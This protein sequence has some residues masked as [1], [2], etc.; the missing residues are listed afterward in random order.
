MD[1]SLEPRKVI[2]LIDGLCD[3]GKGGEVCVVRTSVMVGSGLC[4]VFTFVIALQL[5]TSRNILTQSIGL[6]PNIDRF[7]DH[8]PCYV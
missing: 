2:V 4:T 5:K 8:S 6:L 1:T 3:F 7:V